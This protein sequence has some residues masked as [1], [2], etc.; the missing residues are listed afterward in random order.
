[1]RM[2]LPAVMIIGLAAL[3]SVANAGP[4]GPTIEAA[5]RG[6]RKEAA[7]NQIAVRGRWMIVVHESDGTPVSVTTFD[8]AYVDNQNFL[9]EVL[10]GGRFIYG[11]GVTLRHQNSSPCQDENGASAPCRCLTPG[12]S[13]EQNP[14]IHRTL[15]AE[16]D[17][18]VVSLRGTVVAAADGLIGNVDVSLAARSL[19]YD[20]EAVEDATLTQFTHFGFGITR[21][22]LPQAVAV[23]EGQFIQVQVDISFG[24]TN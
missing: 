23:A 2:R 8:N 12:F 17:G 24:P 5:E 14:S 16:Q 3:A 13:G 9:P 20:P 15:S 18:G 6:L 22:T 11:H 4:V 21:H 1:M 10:L 19:D 7:E